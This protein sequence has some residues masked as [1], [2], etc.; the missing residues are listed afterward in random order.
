MSLLSALA[1]PAQSSRL[2]AGA[3]PILDASRFAPDAFSPR[4]DVEPSKNEK[5]GG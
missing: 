4:A 2:I 1:S 5:L 3:Q